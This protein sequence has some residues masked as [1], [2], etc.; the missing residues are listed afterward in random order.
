MEGCADCLSAQSCSQCVEG[1]DLDPLTLRCVEGNKNFIYIV[2]GAVLVGAVL[3]VVVVI[4][5]RRRGGKKGRG[6][7]EDKLNGSSLQD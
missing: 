3:V 6:R 4:I 5:W 7:R 1:Y 2:L